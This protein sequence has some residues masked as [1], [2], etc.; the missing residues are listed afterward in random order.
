MRRYPKHRHQYIE[1]VDDPLLVLEHRGRHLVGHPGTDQVALG[2]LVGSQVSTFL[3]RSNCSVRIRSRY[4]G[5]MPSLLAMP[6]SQ[7]HGGA[8]YPVTL[9]NTS[10]LN[11]VYPALEVLQLLSGHRQ[12]RSPAGQRPSDQGYPAAIGSAPALA[13]LVIPGRKVS[14]PPERQDVHLQET[15]L[16]TSHGS[17]DRPDKSYPASVVTSGT[18]ISGIACFGPDRKPDHVSLERI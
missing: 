5:G 14:A 3:S 6:P 2:W 15:P 9:W 12:S 17:P 4:C 13:R 11:W 8:K 16:Q 10:H 1:I 7:S 18:R